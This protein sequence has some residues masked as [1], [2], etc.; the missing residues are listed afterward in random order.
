MKEYSINTIKH[1]SINPVKHPRGIASHEKG[2]GGIYN[3]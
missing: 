1:H 3:A 2:G